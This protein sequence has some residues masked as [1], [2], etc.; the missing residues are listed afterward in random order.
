[1]DQEARFLISEL[2]TS[3]SDK[4]YLTY[5]QQSNCNEFTM[6]ENV[7]RGG[8]SLDINNIPSGRLAGTD[9]ALDAPRFFGRLFCHKH[10]TIQTITHGFQPWR[11]HGAQPS[12]SE[13]AQWLSFRIRARLL[14]LEDIGQ[15][16]DL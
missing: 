4:G 2:M 14:K 7:L 5:S 8:R 3:K 6:K 16:D 9:R 12:G 15:G 11:E 10:R 13:L 1:M